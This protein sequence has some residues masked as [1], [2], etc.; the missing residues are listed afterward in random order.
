MIDQT[1]L[2][3]SWAGPVAVNPS[4]RVLRTPHAIEGVSA[5]AVVW[6]ARVSEREMSPTPLT[7]SFVSEGGAMRA[8]V[9]VRDPILCPR[10][11]LRINHTPAPWG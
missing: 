9:L 3:E 11:D 7:C 10:G 1:W 6:L 5:C 2:A 4:L 8:K